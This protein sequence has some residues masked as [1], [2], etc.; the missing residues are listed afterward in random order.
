MT[1]TFTEPPSERQ[2]SPTRHAKLS[3]QVLRQA[4]EN[5]RSGWALP[6]V[7]A[8]VAALLIGGAA[9]LPAL[10]H[11]TTPAAHG[12]LPG[13]TVAT[14]ITTA[15]GGAVTGR[16][17]YDPASGSYL[18]QRGAE[19]LADPSPDLR[20]TALWKDTFDQVRIVPAGQAL[21][22]RAGLVD[23][24]SIQEWTANP[25]IT[26][27]SD[28]GSRYYLATRSGRL[29]G[30]DP[31]THSVVSRTDLALPANEQDWTL[32]SADP[33][34]G[35]TVLSHSGLLHS[36]D[37]TGRSLGS[38]QVAKAQAPHMIG[39]TSVSIS[40]D[41]ARLAVSDSDGERALDLRTGT[42]VRSRAPGHISMWLDADHYV[43]VETTA[44]HTEAYLVD[45][46]T[47]RVV[48][49]PAR[50]PDTDDGSSPDRLVP[51]VGPAPPGAVTI[52]F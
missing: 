29:L 35:F 36:F 22:Q 50:L 39:G 27:W 19:W 16:K 49:N 11:E 47:G 8:A 52:T 38:R 28:D 23:P 20:H 46:G 40:P 2:L 6:A 9:T 5:K 15:E 10:R 14:Y 51:L 32:V 33:H 17:I 30:I 13:M 31:A 21:D 43:S 41:H 25:R 44:D 26:R 4:N 45:A 12:P 42:Q 34:T 1:M 18:V 48:G 3:A 7:A 24:K 37:A